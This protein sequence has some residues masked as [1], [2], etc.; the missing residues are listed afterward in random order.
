MLLENKCELKSIE[1]VYDLAKLKHKFSFQIKEYLHDLLTCQMFGGRTYS[2]YPTS[3]MRSPDASYNKIRSK[4]WFSFAYCSDMLQDTWHFIASQNIK[5]INA[6]REN[7]KLFYLAMK[8]G[9]INNISLKR[10]SER[11]D[12]K[13]LNVRD[14][15]QLLD[16][17][18][19]KG[20]ITLDKAKQGFIAGYPISI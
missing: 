12:Y 9:I 18:L 2:L 6:L 20:L 3:I 4:F 14:N 1:C 13:G 8:N 5:T 10:L 19:N 17:L 7:P 15:K 16:F 11:D